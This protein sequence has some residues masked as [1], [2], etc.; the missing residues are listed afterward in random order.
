MIG[1]WGWSVS[2]TVKASAVSNWLILLNPDLKDALLPL[3]LAQ[4]NPDLVVVDPDHAPDLSKLPRSTIKLAYLSIGEA[5]HYRPYWARISSAPFLAESNKEWEGN[6]RVDFRDP[7]WQKILLE[8]EIPRRLSQGYDGF[9]LDTL[10]AIPYLEK[11]YP[12][13]YAGMQDALCQWLKQLRLRYPDLLIAANGTESLVLAAPFVDAYV[14][15][16]LFATWDASGKYYRK[17]KAE[18]KTWRHAQLR[19][20]LALHNRPVWNVE[21][22]ASGQTVLQ[23]WAKAQ[24]RQQGFIPFVSERELNVLHADSSSPT[25]VS[26]TVLALYD[27]SEN[28]TDYRN[29]IYE[30]AAFVLNHLGLHVLY[31][32][33]H[34]GFPPEA[35]LAGVRGVITWFADNKMKDPTAYCRWLAQQAAAGRKV[36]ILDALGAGEDFSGR[37]T[38]METL[39]QA[40]GA[41]GLRYKGEF[42]NNALH[43]TIRRKEKA[44]VEFERRLDGDALIYEQWISVDPLNHVY[45]TIGR[46]DKTGSDSDIVVIGPHGGFVGPGYALYSNPNT[47]HAQWRINPFTFFEKALGLTGMPRADITTRNGRRILYVH[48]DG[49]GMAN[50]SGIQD[51]TLGYGLSRTSAEIIRDRY[52]KRFPWPAT[53]SVIE[54]EVDPA[55][56]ADPKHE[57]IA[58]SLFALPNVEAGSH[59]FSHPLDW[60]KQL[61]SFALPPYSTNVELEAEQIAA[62][63]RYPRAALV[64]GSPEAFW[65][66]EITQSIR[67]I[68][69]SLL[70]PE[71]RV[72][73]FQWSGNC[74]PPEGALATLRSLHVRNINGGDGRLDARRPSYTSLAPFYEP[75]GEE[76]QVHSSNA[77]DNVYLME[78]DGGHASFRNVIETFEKTDS[79][80]RVLPINIYYHFF[81]AQAPASVAALDDVYAAVEKWKD[82]TAPLFTSEFVETIHGFLTMTIF[83]QGDGAWQIRNGQ[84]C[85]TVR[86]DEEAREPDLTR[87]RGVAGFSRWKNHLYIH[88][89]GEDP[90]ILY[91]ASHPPPRPHVEESSGPVYHWTARSNGYTFDTQAFEPTTVKLAGFPQFSTR[92]FSLTQGP[93]VT[94]LTLR[95]DARGTFML[96]LPTAGRYKVSF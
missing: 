18:E 48:I 81:S 20:A 55:L 33:I 9:M 63:S 6:Q 83:R 15:E 45:L 36:V 49:D 94:V 84:S 71:K 43:L 54:A 85:R 10:D 34:Q 31:H 37:R 16:G 96:A 7:A 46:R 47:F 51:R 92:T 67:Y 60:S 95:A 14:T 23:T 27:S 42:S 91:L 79:P 3:R 39:N 76:I 22:A 66:K 62:E 57:A 77:N 40:F 93:R 8:E 1:S 52:L 17:V 53:V 61:V 13:R 78:T 74:R 59:S 88:L 86:F 64:K 30:R 72:R 69:T 87:S 82:R 19:R 29:P 44:M 68:E 56:G 90:A 50:A 21:Y 80:R 2:P 24:S 26:R 58:R 41:L 70:P 89:T 32:D 4:I 25:S 28:M 73:L 12:K 38:S 5:E 35:V 11:T 65:E 75:R